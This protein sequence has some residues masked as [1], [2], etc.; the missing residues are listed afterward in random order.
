MTVVESFDQSD[1]SEKDVFLGRVLVQIFR[2]TF[3]IQTLKMNPIH[4]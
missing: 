1:D 3:H 4:M 2:R